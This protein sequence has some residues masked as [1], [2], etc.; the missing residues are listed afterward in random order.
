MN[1]QAPTQTNGSLSGCNGIPAADPFNRV[2]SAIQ[3]CEASGIAVPALSDLL[4][5]KTTTLNAR[6]R[7]EHIE[8]RTV[9][10]TNYIPCQLA[11]HLAELHKYAL[12]G[13]PTLH[14]AS[15]ATAIK[16]AT[17]KARCEKGQLEGHLDLT[18][19]LRVNPVAL[20]RLQI[21]TP[22]NWSRTVERKVTPPVAKPWTN[23]RPPV[24]KPAPDRRDYSAPPTPP[25][26]TLTPVPVPEVRVLTRKDYGF[27]EIQSERPRQ[28]AN[29]SQNKPKPEGLLGYDPDRPFC[30]SECRVG[31][32]IVYGPYEGRIVKILDDPFSPKIQVHFPD[33]DLPV[34]REVLLTVARRKV[35]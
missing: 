25:R 16:P 26:L 20:G 29:G 22:G 11:I 27:P 19:R 9:G 23:P 7:R 4:G 12:I 8:V 1:Q 17:I 33:H 35:A 10:R 13:W 32:P 5:V 34:M 24:R 14:E 30:V 31:K 15:K 18:K 21:R 2:L 3:T 28:A 6:F